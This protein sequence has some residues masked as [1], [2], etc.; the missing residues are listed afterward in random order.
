MAY[1]SFTRLDRIVVEYSRGSRDVVLRDYG[2]FE[3]FE[4]EIQ[5]L[6]DQS[7]IEY[8]NRTGNRK[9]WEATY[10]QFRSV[11]RTW[12]GKIGEP[13]NEIG[14]L[15]IKICEDMEDYIE[16]R[17]PHLEYR[18]LSPFARIR[19]IPFRKDQFEK[20]VGNLVSQNTKEADFWNILEGRN[21]EEPIDFLIPA[22]SIRYFFDRLITVD[23]LSKRKSYTQK[24]ADCSLTGT[25]R[26]GESAVHKPDYPPTDS[27]EE[28]IVETALFY[29]LGPF[30]P[31]K[32]QET[33]D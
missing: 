2:D 28:D 6:R 4:H 9:E 31:E 23:G 25:Q 26:I 3:H 1:E 24:I 29:L 14:R 19:E 18:V 16:L 27:A 5:I 30:A 10:H 32:P 12:R 21:A 33:P 22:N 7:Q 20:L 15:L 8:L 17:S 13:K 11:I